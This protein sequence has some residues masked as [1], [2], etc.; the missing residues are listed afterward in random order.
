MSLH[1]SITQEDKVLIFSSSLLL[2]LLPSLLCRSPNLYFQCEAQKYLIMQGFNCEKFKI[3]QLVDHKH[4]SVA[5]KQQ[6]C[7]MADE[8]M[9]HHSKRRCNEVNN[10]KEEV[11]YMYSTRSAS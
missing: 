1:T 10:D 8:L 6:K 2:L 11:Q 7:T 9:S 5:W 4:P 3:N